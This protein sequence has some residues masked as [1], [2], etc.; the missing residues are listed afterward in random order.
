M[1]Q[2]DEISWKVSELG[3]TAVLLEPQVE[4]NH[5]K[6]IQKL[7]SFI[8]SD[9]HA[10]ILDVVPAYQSIAIFYLKSKNEVLN[11]LENINSISLVSEDTHLYN[12]EVDYEQGLD[13]GR[14][15]DYTG[16][17]KSEIIERH[18]SVEYTVAMIGF[19]PGF[20]FLEGLDPA[21]SVSRLDIPRTKIPAGSIG[22]GGNQTG[23]YSIESPGGWNIIGNSRFNF[24]DIKKDPPISISP[25]DKIKFIPL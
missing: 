3:K 6:Y 2:L 25:G 9:T 17:S 11:Y 12:V 10:S 14:V 8:E 19:V 5:L 23:L 15:S 13:W 22:I 7:Y 21:L 20:L 18:S 24:F 4:E 16:F 1:L